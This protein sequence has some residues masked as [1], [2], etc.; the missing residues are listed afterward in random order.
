MKVLALIPA[1]THVDHRLQEALGRAGVSWHPFYECS[2][3]PKARSQLLTLGLDQSDAD[4]FLLLDSDMNPSAE[5]LHSL[6]NHAAFGPM[7]AI[8]GAYPTREGN[9][10]AAPLDPL[11]SVTLGDDIEAFPLEAAGLGCAIIHRVALQRIAK[12]LKPVTVVS[13]GRPWLP[14]CLPFVEA[15]TY[16]PDDYALWRRLRAA[17]GRVWL[18]P[19]LLIPHLIRGPRVPIHGTVVGP[20]APPAPT[21]AEAPPAPSAGKPARRKR[22]PAKR[23]R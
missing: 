22:T 2:D 5:Q 8:V 17:G 21:P 23:R 15:G 12:R 11:A 13:A 10:A 6:L 3:L 19:N 4:V 20:V 14:F 16:Y 7:D 9:L 18:A 1:Y